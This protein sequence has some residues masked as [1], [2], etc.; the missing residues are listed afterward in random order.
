M[1]YSK[2]TS[3]IAVHVP[4]TT[5]PTTTGPTAAPPTGKIYNFIHSTVVE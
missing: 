2:N 5:L 4:T 3:I 1:K